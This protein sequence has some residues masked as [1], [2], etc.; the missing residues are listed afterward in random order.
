MAGVEDNL[1]LKLEGG[2]CTTTDNS[3]VSSMVI[4]NDASNVPNTVKLN[5]SNYPFWSKVLEMHMVGHGKKGTWS[6]KES[7]EES[8]EYDAWETGN[9]IVK[10]MLINSMDPIIMVKSFRLRKE[11]H[12]ISVYYADLK[13]I[14]QELDQRRPIKMECALALKTLQEEI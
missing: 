2:P 1:R 11:G 10:G 14:W 7:K 5:G 4:H 9:A 12:P 3:V 8:A 6:I 13:A